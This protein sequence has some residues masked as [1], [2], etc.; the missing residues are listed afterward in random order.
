MI[1]ENEL[2]KRYST[3]A[4]Y[5]SPAAIDYF[6]SKIRTFYYCEAEFGDLLRDYIEHLLFPPTD[7]CF[8][9]PKPTDGVIRGG[10]M[11]MS[12][13]EIKWASVEYE[14]RSALNN[15]T[16]SKVKFVAKKLE[17]D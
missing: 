16:G 7:K 17:E 8:N 12:D 9:F 1:T 13:E 14:L 11:T 4:I 2:C 15:F 6:D 5:V 3:G 10:G